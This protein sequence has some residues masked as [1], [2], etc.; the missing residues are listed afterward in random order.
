MV[1]APIVVD[2]KGEFNALFDNLKAKGFKQVRV[3]GYVKD[4]SEDLFLIKIIPPQKS[5]TS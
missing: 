5:P 4:T 3:D 1:L 2:K